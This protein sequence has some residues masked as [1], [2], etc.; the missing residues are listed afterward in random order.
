MDTPRHHP[1]ADALCAYAAGAS[2]PDEELLLACHLT[3]CPAC[4][5]EVERAEA[6]AGALSPEA[7]GNADVERWLAQVAPRL[8]DPP[9]PPPAPP[10]AGGSGAGT[11]AI[12][13]PAPIRRRLA[14]PPAF[15]AVAPGLRVARV[16]AGAG[17]RVFLADFRPG[18]R[19]PDHGH[20]GVERGL[21]LRGGFRWGPDAYAVGDVSWE[22]DEHRDIVVD[23]DGPCTT[24]F[25]ND[26]PLSVGSGWLDRALDWWLLG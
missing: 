2:D 15:R 21:V 7:D 13:L 16:P 24:L 8:D 5:A 9:P 19:V 23:D 3:V 14:G 17:A 22:E 12:P 10:P 1:P 20:H 18:F 26:G 6:L 11:G 25:V 4:R